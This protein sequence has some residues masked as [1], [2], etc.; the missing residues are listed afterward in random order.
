MRCVAKQV[1]L[2]MQ[3]FVFLLSFRYELIKVVKYSALRATNNIY[4]YSFS[5]SCVPVGNGNTG[6]KERERDRAQLHF[7]RRVNSRIFAASPLGCQSMALVVDVECVF[8]FL[9]STQ[10]LFKDVWQFLYIQVEMFSTF[11]F[12]HCLSARPS[13]PFQSPDKHSSKVFVLSLLL[14]LVLLLL[15]L[16]LFVSSQLARDIS[17]VLKS[18]RPAGWSYPLLPGYIFL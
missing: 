2:F 4:S 7:T 11:L 8:V 5:S 9:L 17:D 6:A 13:C 15:L 3:K 1:V 12:V 16:L 10:R 18:K 14:C